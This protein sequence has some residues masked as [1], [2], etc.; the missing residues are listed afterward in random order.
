MSYQNL[1]TG[2]I[3]LIAL[4]YI[5]LALMGALY[6]AVMYYV[7]IVIKHPEK[8]ADA[9]HDARLIFLQTALP[10]PVTGLVAVALSGKAFPFMAGDYRYEWTFAFAGGV[11]ASAIVRRFSRTLTTL[12]GLSG[13]TNDTAAGGEDKP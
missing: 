8:E 7:P 12:T 3:P 9:R 6:L 1:T 11:T 10:A 13:S 4:L 2:F 5:L